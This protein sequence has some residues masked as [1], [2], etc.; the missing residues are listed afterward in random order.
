M[1][2]HNNNP[3]PKAIL[4]ICLNTSSKCYLVCSLYMCFKLIT[5]ANVWPKWV[6]IPTGIPQQYLPM[7]MEIVYCTLHCFCASSKVCNYK[8]PA[9]A[10]FIKFAKMSQLGMQCLISSEIDGPQPSTGYHFP[11]STRYT[12]FA[13]WKSPGQPI[14]YT[15]WCTSGNDGRRYYG[16]GRTLLPNSSKLQ[17]ALIDISIVLSTRISFLVTDYSGPIQYVVQILHHPTHHA[18]T[19]HLLTFRAQS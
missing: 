15:R 5:P 7:C 12:T 6:Q 9:V 17:P 13:T 11:K 18:T 1:Q 4:L 16:G 3:P 10:F 8:S 14:H 2:A 19:L